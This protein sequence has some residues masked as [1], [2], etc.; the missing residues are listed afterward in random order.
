MMHISMIELK[1]ALRRCFEASGYFVGN[2]EDAAD[3]IVWLEKHGLQGLAEFKSMLPYLCQD[4]DKPLSTIVYEDS[5]A[6]V[7]DSHNRSSLNC[8]AAAVDVAYLKAQQAGIATVTVRNCHNRRFVLKAITDCGRRGVSVAAYWQ[9]GKNKVTEYTASIK[10][11]HRY[12][13]YSEALTDLSYSD[14]QQQSLTII[15]SARVDLQPSLKKGSAVGEILYSS[16]QKI[17]ENKQHSV[18]QGI[19]IST[20]LWGEINRIGE[21]VLVES[22]DQSRRGAG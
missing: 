1:A 6:I 9:N 13:N 16:A 5:G 2:Y 14:Q 12:P 8:I 22:T 18:E 19:E 17:A 20:D 4:Q 3:M 7:I 21:G 11:G 10:A 15:C